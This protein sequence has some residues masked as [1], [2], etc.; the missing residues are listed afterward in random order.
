MLFEW[1]EEKNDLNIVKHGIDFRFASEVFKSDD[2][3]FEK[4]HKHSQNEERFFAIGTLNGKKITVRFTMRGESIR[5]IGA[6][7]WR[8][9]K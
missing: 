2:L 1:D 4:D 9:F 5:I 7:Y 6:G 3:H 8:K